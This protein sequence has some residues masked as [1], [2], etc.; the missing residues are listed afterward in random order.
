MNA[1][2]TAVQN[3]RGQALAVTGMFLLALLALIAVLM[4]VGHLSYGSHEVKIAAEVAASARAR[5]MTKQIFA[6]I[7][8]N[9]TQQ[10]MPP[11]YDLASIA[12][13]DVLV[14][15]NPEGGEPHGLVINGVALSATSVE[16]GN[17]TCAACDPTTT[18]CCEDR[19]DPYIV[20]QD[21]YHDGAKF[22]CLSQLE[23][24]NPDN[25]QPLELQINAARAIACAPLAPI[26]AGLLPGS[27]EGTMIQRTA[28]SA[29]TP[30]RSGVPV[31]PIAIADCQGGMWGG[32]AC[33]SGGNSCTPPSN[34]SA[35]L[36][37]PGLRLSAPANATNQAPTD[38]GWF[39]LGSTQPTSTSVRQYLPASCGGGGVSYGTL[40]VGNTIAVGALSDDALNGP[41]YNL[42]TDIQSC[43]AADGPW[44]LAENDEENP[45]RFLVPMVSNPVEDCNACPALCSA[46]P[47]CSTVVRTIVG[48]A[49]VVVHN[50]CAVNPDTLQ[51]SCV[52]AGLGE[53]APA[54][55]GGGF[56]YSGIP[57][58]DETGSPGGRNFGTGRFALV[59]EWIT[60]D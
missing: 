40:S 48:F 10:A 32:L 6:V 59:G 4:N 21:G 14:G 56:A 18:N 53:G 37:Y 43:F 34:L 23:V 27:R 16:V 11:P 42:L 31:L 7:Q 38:S 58:V 29:F 44:R 54:S 49:T 55:A 36:C 35:L 51:R 20:V 3:E 25:P 50:V 19:G 26:F 45:T 33:A 5:T 47:T 22:T 57:N 30:I 9:I 1:R 52:V 46:P 17:A 28:I 8:A 15:G 60:G 39:V 12:P 2:R 24:G 13:V 41:L